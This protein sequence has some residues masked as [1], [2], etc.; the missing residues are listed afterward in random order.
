MTTTLKEIK[1][2]NGNILEI[3]DSLNS[4]NFWIHPPNS[5]KG[6]KIIINSDQADDIIMALKLS[7]NVDLD[8]N[9]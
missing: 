4:L 6:L 1:S 7:R 5:T 8:I 2:S 3:Y 9:Y